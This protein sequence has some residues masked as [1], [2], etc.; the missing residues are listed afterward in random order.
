MRFQT[1]SSL[2]VFLASGS[3][4]RQA[5]TNS[6][7]SFGNRPSGVNRGAG[8]FT[9][10][11]RSSRML[12][13][14]PPPCRLTPLLFLLSF[15]FVF[16]FVGSPDRLRTPGREGESVF[17]YSES[18]SSSDDCEKG[19]RPRAN[20]IREIPRDHTSDLTVYCAPC[21]RSGFGKIKNIIR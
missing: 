14:M 2:G 20:S 13:V 12:I 21:I 11:C 17:S 3:F 10:C 4:N 16:C 1:R 7:A 8:S 6:S 15:F 9:I 19:N 5:S 18:V